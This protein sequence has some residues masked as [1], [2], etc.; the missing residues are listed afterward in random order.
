M[1]DER[2]SP[3][4]PPAAVRAFVTTLV[5]DAV[6]VALIV[7]ELVFDAGLVFLV[8][9]AAIVVVNMFW[10]RRALLRARAEQSGGGNHGDR[11]NTRGP[12]DHH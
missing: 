9:G 1:T 8:V 10:F 5:V 11:P 3:T 2:P 4:F 6:A 7:A 12:I